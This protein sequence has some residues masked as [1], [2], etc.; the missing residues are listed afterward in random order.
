MVG[1]PDPV[2]GEVVSAFVVL[3]PGWSPAAE[4]AADLQEHVK[5]M[6]APYKYPRRV[7]FVTELPKTVSGKIRRGEL[8]A[9][10]S[11]P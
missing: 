10:H 1:L 9:A 6:T 2:R 7:E 8:R 11:R 5:R 3:R 4:L